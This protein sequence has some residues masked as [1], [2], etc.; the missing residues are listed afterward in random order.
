VEYYNR[1]EKDD[2]TFEKELAVHKW[3]CKIGGI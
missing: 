3:D 2:G 1:V